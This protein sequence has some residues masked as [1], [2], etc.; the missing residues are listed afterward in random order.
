M[1]M[2]LLL[3]SCGGGEKENIGEELD[4]VEEIIIEKDAD[5]IS[6]GEEIYT[7]ICVACHQ[8]NGK[9]VPTVFPPLAESDYLLSD[10]NR[11][12]EQILNGSQGKIEV[13]GESFKG[14][15]PPQA[16]T[17]EQVRDVLNYVL[18]SWGNDGGVVTLEDVV[19]AKHPS[20]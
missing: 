18:N 7:K 3:A 19:N 11:A 9:G 15:M 17:D 5:Y 13:N 1:I 20:K 2:T 8:L 6:S 4:N 16:L 10:K 12:I 14:I